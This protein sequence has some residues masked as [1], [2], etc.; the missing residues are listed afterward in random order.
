MEDC[1]TDPV[2][3]RLGMVERGHPD[4]SLRGSP[5][6]VAGRAGRNRRH[7]LPGVAQGTG[8]LD[9]VLAAAVVGPSALADGRT[10]GRPL[11]RR[12]VAAAGGG[13]LARQR[14]TYPGQRA[15]FLRSPF[16]Q[17]QDGPVSE[18]KAPREAQPPQGQDGAAGQ[19]AALGHVA[20]AYGLAHA[21]EL[22]DGALVCRRTRAFPGDASG[23]EIPEAYAVLRRCRLCRLRIVESAERQGPG[24]SDSRRSQR[25]GAAPGGLYPRT[26]GNRVLL[27]IPMRRPR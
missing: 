6:L 17:G 10:W 11:A 15:G 18:E 20:V 14:A 27:A 4:G 8:H 19:A 25:D 21:L 26:C 22:E 9:G 7:D 16:R 2:D 5:A 13:R 12:A 24:L 1:R 23:A 3:G